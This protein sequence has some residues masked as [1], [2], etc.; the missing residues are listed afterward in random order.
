MREKRAIFDKKN[1]LVIGGAGFIGSHLCDELIKTAK[2]ICVDNYVSGNV[3][4]ISQ[5]LQHPNFIFL[6]HDINQPLDLNSFP[7]L[8]LF[9][10]EFQGV[11][12]IYYLACPTNQLGFE[13]LAIMT[14]RTN[15]TGVIN[16]LELARQYQAKFLFGSTRS[17]YGDPLEGQE[18]FAEEYWGF[19]DPLSERACY[20]EGKRFAETI[21]RT[22]QRVYKLDTKIARIFNVYGPRMRLNSGRMIPD[23]VRSAIDR[24]DLVIYGDGSAQDSYCYID[25]MVAGLTALM[26][27][28]I[29]D[30]V[31]LGNQEMSTIIDVA[32]IIIE[33]VDTKSNVVFED[34]I[35]GLV[36]PALPDI[37]RAKR[38]LGWFPVVDLRAGLEK[39]IADMRGSRVLTYHE[40]STDNL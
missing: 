30:P 23:F 5:I 33:L 10:V 26:Q 21:T 24:Q 34:S 12:E 37:K 16:A 4:N 3:D 19:V 29:N 28:N 1:I 9:Q 27:S 6:R 20:N 11:Q 31:N 14:A 7:E 40:S 36:K 38:L 15:S 18:F 35:S 32:N 13:D 22:Y 2:V 8:E 17:I 39:T 25:D